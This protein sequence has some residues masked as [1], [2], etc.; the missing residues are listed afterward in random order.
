MIHPSST[1]QIT[2]LY[3]VRLLCPSQT[4]TNS[5]FPTDNYSRGYVYLVITGKNINDLDRNTPA[6]H[7]IHLHGHD[8]VILAQENS[9]F[10]GVQNFTFNN[11]PRRDVALLYAG[12]YLAL[13]FKPDNP[14]IWL[15][16]RPL[17]E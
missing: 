15:V 17:G 12:G 14:G 5:H 4:A 2:A 11:P 9:T 13:A 7:P 16:S 1:A 10:T 8:F 6:A 3:L